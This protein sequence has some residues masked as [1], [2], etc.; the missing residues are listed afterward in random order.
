MTKLLASSKFQSGKLKLYGFSLPPDTSRCRYS[1]WSRVTSNSHDSV[2][3]HTAVSGAEMVGEPRASVQLQRC[4]NSTN[5]PS[6]NDISQRGRRG[7]G[8]QPVATQPGGATKHKPEERRSG[9]AARCGCGG[10]SSPDEVVQVSVIFIGAS[11]TSTT[12]TFHQCRHI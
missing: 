4:C 7:K 5:G 2:G 6:C 9:A 10:S 8:L 12:M 11:I 3:K 1:T